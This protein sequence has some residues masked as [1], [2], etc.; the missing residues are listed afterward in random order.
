M[1]D[2]D[3]DEFAGDRFSFANVGDTAWGRVTNIEARTG[4]HGKVPVLTLV[5]DKNGTT[6]ELW[7]GPTN[8]KRQLADLRPQVGDSLRVEFIAQE[9]TGQPSPMKVFVVDVKRGG[10]APDPEPVPAPPAYDDGE[11]PF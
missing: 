8:L 1:T 2:F 4:Q 11:E 7:A 9:H 3:W 5:V 10:E 6:R